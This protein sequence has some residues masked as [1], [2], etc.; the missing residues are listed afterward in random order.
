LVLE[1]R[2]K[3]KVKAAAVKKASVRVPGEVREPV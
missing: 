3:E 1:T 2:V